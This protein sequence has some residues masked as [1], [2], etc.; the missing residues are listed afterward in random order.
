MFALVPTRGV[1]AT[2]G[3][4]ELGTTG[5]LVVPKRPGA[6]VNG[7]LGV[8][9]DAGVICGIITGGDVVDAASVGIIGIPVE[10]GNMLV[11]G[12]GA[13]APTSPIIGV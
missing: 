8:L 10:T 4:A 3:R 5:G 6:V 11:G 12:F 2:P 1:K 9:V 7:K 13:V